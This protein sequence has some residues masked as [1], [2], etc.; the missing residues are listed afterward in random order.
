M[1][2]S[3]ILALPYADGIAADRFLSDFGY[4]LRDANVAIAGLVQRNTFVR[5]RTKC[6]MEFEELSSGNILRL[7]ENRGAGA[8]GCRLDRGVLSAAAAMLLQILEADRKPGLLILNKFGKIEAEG[9]GLRDVI[10]SA[11]GMEIPVIVGVPFR[12]LDQWRAFAGEF[13]EEG[14]FD[15][16][17]LDAWLER[18][19]IV[20]CRIHRGKPSGITAVR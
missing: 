8:R 5:D 7:S 12:N 15:D 16:Q 2:G 4:R 18:C 17:S 6:D 1:G 11:L 9:A 13:A 10:A 19:N 14:A 3:S 20:A